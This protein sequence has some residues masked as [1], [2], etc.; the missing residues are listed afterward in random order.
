MIHVVHQRT[1]YRK[2]RTPGEVMISG[3][4]ICYSLEDELRE[5]PGVPV[6]Q[7][8]VKGKTAIPAG[9]Y[10]L[11]LVDSP[12]FGKDTLALVPAPGA[13]CGFAELRVHGGNDEDDTEGC[14]LMGAELD[15][16]DRIPGGKSQP[17]LK[18]LRAAVVPALKAGEEVVWDVRNPPG[19]VGP[20]AADPEATVP[21]RP[22][23]A[24]TAATREDAP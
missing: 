16:D 20:P 24:K 12:R 22:R 1:K 23:G 9:H 2:D 17:G 10:N 19:Y 13:D 11:R 7:W 4:R 8:K 6:A 14:P 18:A 15:A 21:P 3:Q 5:L